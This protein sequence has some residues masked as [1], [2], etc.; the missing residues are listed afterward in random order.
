MNRSAEKRPANCV[1][2]HEMSPVDT[3][4][5]GLVHPGEESEIAKVKTVPM[6]KMK[7]RS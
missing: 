1:M 6:L 3:C 2:L 7:C 4:C 5:I